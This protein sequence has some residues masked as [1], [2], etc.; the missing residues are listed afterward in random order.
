MIL[1]QVGLWTVGGLVLIGM[2]ASVTRGDRTGAQRVTHV[3]IGGF[4]LAVIIAAALTIGG[5]A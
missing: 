1:L 4:I 5:M 3:I 2:L